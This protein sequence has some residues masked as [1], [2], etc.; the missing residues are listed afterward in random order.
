MII[1]R[2]ELQRSRNWIERYGFP[3]N[4]TDCVNDL[5]IARQLV[6][7]AW[8]LSSDADLLIMDGTWHGVLKRRE[9]EILFSII[10][11]LRIRASASMAAYISPQ[12]G[13]VTAWLT[14]LPYCGMGKMWWC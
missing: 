5:G 10:E 11:A 8:G 7:I 12:A 4:P 6:E 13:E 3:L 2:N 1:R 9:S 14:V